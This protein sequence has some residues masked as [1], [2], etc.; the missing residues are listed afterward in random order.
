M[1][2]QVNHASLNPIVSFFSLV[3]LLHKRTSLFSSEE[4]EAVTG[5]ADTEAYQQSDAGT[6]RS[7]GGSGT[8]EGR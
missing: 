3:L 7:S 4:S 5:R 8:R 6:S 2:D 1:A